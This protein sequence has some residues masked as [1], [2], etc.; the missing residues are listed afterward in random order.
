MIL[1]R[2]CKK[3]LHIKHIT[4]PVQNN[5]KSFINALERKEFLVSHNGSSCHTTLPQKIEVVRRN[6]TIVEVLT[7]SLLIGKMIHQRYDSKIK[8]KLVK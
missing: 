4:I 8:Y 5:A 1:F 6:P 7:V 3:S 2:S